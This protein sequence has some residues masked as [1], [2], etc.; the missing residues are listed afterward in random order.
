MAHLTFFCEFLRSWCSEATVLLHQGPP[1]L[2]MET[3]YHDTNSL[4]QTV[5]KLNF[6]I[7]S[8]FLDFII[9]VN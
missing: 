9:P 6:G 1:A 7:V 5:R 4:T 8:R 2:W 3:M